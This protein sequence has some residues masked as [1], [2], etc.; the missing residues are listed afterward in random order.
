MYVPARDFTNTRNQIQ[1]RSFFK[2]RTFLAWINNTIQRSSMLIHDTCHFEARLIKC[3]TNHAICRIAST[4]LTGNYGGGHT[5]VH[6]CIYTHIPT[7]S[8][9]HTTLHLHMYVRAKKRNIMYA[10]HAHIQSIICII[11]SC[12]WKPRLRII[13]YKVKFLTKLCII[14]FHYYHLI[15]SSTVITG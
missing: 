5:C 10:N 13:N 12:S 3:P 2:S 8:V 14:Q 9:I 4:T 6:V 7:Y 11:K 1:L 15:F